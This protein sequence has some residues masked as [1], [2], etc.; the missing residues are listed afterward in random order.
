MDKKEADD[1]SLYETMRW[2][3]WRTAED[4]KDKVAL[5]GAHTRMPA[6]LAKGG[7]GTTTPASVRL[8]AFEEA[9]GETL[10]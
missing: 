5:R 2:T 7:R 8:R 4:E 9:C 10:G 3:P 6:D 1:L